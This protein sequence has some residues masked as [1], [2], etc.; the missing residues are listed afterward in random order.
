MTRRLLAVSCAVLA[1][2]SSCGG[3]REFSGYVRTPAP[4]SQGISLP[5]IGGESLRELVASNGKLLTIYFGYTNC[6]DIC[7][8]TLQD[9][10]VALRRLDDASRVEVAMV[11]VDPDRDLAVLD[12]YVKSFI[13][14]AIALG[15]TD[16]TELAAAAQ[17]FGASYLV[18][19]M[20]TDIEVAHSTSLY[21]VDDQGTL[22]LTWP[23]GVRSSDIS[24]DL[25]DLLDGRRS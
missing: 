2:A 23:F 9:L 13:P 25:N 11:T 16:E 7:P 15:T 22:L 5:V 18:E 6:P 4:S 12:G 21:V 17:P 1:I 24:A 3:T 19:S 10:T 20:S 8:T 14:T